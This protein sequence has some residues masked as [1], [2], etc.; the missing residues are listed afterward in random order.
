MSKKKRE[1]AKNKTAKK[2]TTRTGKP[3]AEAPEEPRQI[4]LTV[5]QVEYLRPIVVGLNNARAAQN[6]AQQLMNSAIEG[7]R[8]GKSTAADGW[9]VDLDRRILEPVT[10]PRPNLL[11][12]K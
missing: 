1:T 10:A 4:F 8:I 7:L 6:V 2:R 9:K 3:K 11:P 12:Q 5:E